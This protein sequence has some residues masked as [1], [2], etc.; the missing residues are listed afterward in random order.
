MQANA[1]DVK[2]DVALGGSNAPSRLFVPSGDVITFQFVN[3]AG[4]QKVEIQEFPRRSDF[5]DKPRQAANQDVTEGQKVDFDPK[6][7]GIILVKVGARRIAAIPMTVAKDLDFFTALG[8]GFQFSSGA[9]PFKYSL[10]S[11]FV[12]GVLDQNTKRIQ[13]D[14]ASRIV[15]GNISGL[16]YIAFNDD[17]SSGKFSIAKLFTLGL[18]NPHYHRYGLVASVGAS[19]DQE[20]IF[21]VG[22]AWFLDR[23]GRT[24]LITGVQ[25]RQAEVLLNDPGISVVDST[26]QLQT[27]RRWQSRFF[28]G[29][30]FNVGK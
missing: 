30:T 5:E 1:I 23:G 15:D 29:L 26:F 9:Q 19:G 7:D 24:A 11:N 12:N 20:P 14:G 6:E 13:K 10:E 18:Y 17:A 25:F 16:A 8:A 22:T 21:Q 3:V 2:I 27:T 4:T 28:I